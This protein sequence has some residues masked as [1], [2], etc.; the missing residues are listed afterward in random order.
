[1]IPLSDI[2]EG[3]AGAASFELSDPGD[4]MAWIDP[5]GVL[6]V[7]G[8][9][10][11]PGEHVVR[12]TATG[13]GTRVPGE[14]T[15]SV[16]SSGRNEVE[17]TFT[18]DTTGRG[19]TS[20]LLAGTFNGW[21]GEG[22]SDAWAMED[23]DH[24]EVW[25]L[26]VE[27][28]PG[29]YQYKFVLFF[30]DGSSHWE[31][32]P[33][34]PDRV[35]DGYGGFNSVLHL[36]PVACGPRLD[37]LDHTVEQGRFTGLVAMTGGEGGVDPGSV[38]VTLDLEPLG[39]EAWTV[40]QD[41]I[42]LDVPGLSRGIHDL[43][44]QATDQGGV[45]TPVLLLKVYVDRSTDWR[46]SILYFAMTDRFAN[47]DPSN[48]G[49][50]VD[51]VPEEASYRGGDFAG[52]TRKIEE[53][54]FDELGVN[55][56]WI[57]W[58]VDNPPFGEPGKV[59]TTDRCN[60]DLGDP[61][62]PTREGYF[63]GYHGYWPA[64][65][66]RVEEHFGTMAEL[67]TLVATAHRRGIQILLDFT[68]NHV[69]QSSS[70]FTDHQDYFNLPPEICSQVGWDVKPVT[71]WFTDFLPDI[72]YTNPAARDAVV[73]MALSWIR[74]TGADGFRFDALKHVDESFIRALR[75]KLRLE[76]E[77]TGVQFYLVGETF[78]GDPNLIARFVGPDLVH[79][80]F[81]FPLNYHLLQTFAKRAE[82]LDELQRAMLGFQAVYQGGLMST[83]IGNHDI[84]R[85]VSVAAGQLWCTEPWNGDHRRNTGVWEMTTNQAVGWLSPPERPEDPGAH[86]SLRLAFAYIMSLPGIPLV[87]YGD[88]FGMPGA[89]DP[90]NRRTMR[91]GDEL[92]DLERD[93]LGFVRALG[94]L[95]S[96]T[97]ALR[98]G[99]LTGYWA[100]QTGLVMGRAQ[101]E[102]VAVLAM[103]L[104]R[105]E[106]TLDVDAGAIGL[107]DG[108][109]LED[110]LG[111]EVSAT[112]SGGRLSLTLPPESAAILIP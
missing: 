36:D 15:F 82:G 10:A 16:G 90:D 24:D 92:S 26:T 40:D 21:G 55:A 72:D 59:P 108:M 73:A 46:D 106:R 45:A 91:F 74:R 39:R 29:D 30:Q 87:Y 61:T 77:Q 98:T 112:V 49:E 111:S 6:W 43:R 79:G 56:I 71:C 32:D 100:D 65:L 86:R 63:S 57:S 58:P 107:V 12:V 104:S 28:A 34:N 94:T 25:T 75:A 5:A 3:T 37:L 97:P 1:M 31:E 70:F 44:I 48:D 66:D 2:T 22:L 54:Y 102:Q 85:F 110:G 69:H 67:Q 88:E 50:A 89:G 80:Q 14:L 81:D 68:A 20:V 60:G 4:L 101:G 41:T 93:T 17:H 109:A 103:N 23:P 47:G 51:R 99:A 18:L 7:S 11:S 76:L 33:R 105:S 19:V 83:F 95:R 53:G 38:A 42:S 27:L 35:D 13:G 64:D 8:F 52:L 9:G 96:R 78:T 84:A 62:Y